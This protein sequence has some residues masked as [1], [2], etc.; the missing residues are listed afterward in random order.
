M[1]QNDIPA[2]HVTEVSEAL[3]Q[4]SRKAFALLGWNG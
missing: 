4:R 1:L 2:L 3:V